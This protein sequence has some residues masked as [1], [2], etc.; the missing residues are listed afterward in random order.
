MKKHK[1]EDVSNWMKEARELAKAER[2]L[3]IE[4]WVAISIEYRNRD[5]RQVVLIRYDLP[6]G[7]Y[8]KYR[9]VIRWR[10][11]RC[12]CLY[13]REDIQVCHSCYDKRTGLR[14]GFNSCLSRLAASK[15]QITIAKKKEQEYLSFQRQNNLF[16]DE[17]TD[18]SLVEF[19]EKLKKK[20]ENCN[21]LLVN[22][23]NAVAAH[24]LQSKNKN[25]E[26]I[27]NTNRTHSRKG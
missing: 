24:N 26:T 9:W 12:Q 3:K 20:E 1:Q 5:C 23:Q 6:R 11:A 10:Q 14:T 17:N 15:A 18:K 21:M 8:E 2:E 27:I 25:N 22:I 19:R 4:K 16:F 13:P 7:L